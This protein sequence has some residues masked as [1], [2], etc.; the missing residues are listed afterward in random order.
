MLETAMNKA[1]LMPVLLLISLSGHAADDSELDPYRLNS[2]VQPLSQQLEM[3]LDPRLENYSGET[4]ISLDVL[5]DID[6]ILLHA[7]D[8]T[9]VSAHLG[10]GEALESAEFEQLE[11]A[12][13]RISTGSKIVAGQYQLRIRFEDDFNTDSVSMYRVKEDGRFHIFSQME[14][15]EAREAFP[16]F[17][18]PAYKIPWSLT[19]TVPADMMAISNTPIAE[20]TDQGEMTRG[21]VRR[22]GTD[23]LLPDCCRR[24]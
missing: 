24:W 18:E 9:I 20:S 1:L 16:C 5:E 14:A 11:H 22:I 3:T 21:R 17:D 23:A 6:F 19:L 2:A 8:M 12:L 10:Q 15:S 7:Q 13:L 4:L